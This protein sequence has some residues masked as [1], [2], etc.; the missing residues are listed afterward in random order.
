MARL[1]SWSWSESIQLFHLQLSPSTSWGSTRPLHGRLEQPLALDLSLGIWAFSQWEH[2]SLNSNSVPSL[3]FLFT[4]KFHHRARLLMRQIKTENLFGVYK[5][6]KTTI[7][8]LGHFC[9]LDLGV[10]S[11]IR[12][13]CNTRSPPCPSLSHTYPTHQGD[14]ICPSWDLRGEDMLS[15]SHSISVRGQSSVSSL[16]MRIFSPSRHANDF[17]HLFFLCYLHNFLPAKVRAVKN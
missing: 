7:V 13:H 14:T 9:Y 3:R 5:A 12:E 15:M 10:F 2:S 17:F 1:V 8:C 11:S 6:N 16:A 4:K